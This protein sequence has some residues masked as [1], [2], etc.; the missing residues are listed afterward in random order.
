[1]NRLQKYALYLLDLDGL[2]VNTEQL[3]YEAY[4]QMCE[5]RGFQLDL[6]FAAYC[7][8]AH[9]SAQGIEQ[10]IYAHFPALHAKEPRWS[11]LYAEK[12]LLMSNSCT[13]APLS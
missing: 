9:R 2:L 11:V 8:I 5:A 7:E 6:T 13:R 1:M 3:H 10:H 4:V 12:K